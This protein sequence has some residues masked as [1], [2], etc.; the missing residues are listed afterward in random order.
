M[1]WS[2][3][4]DRVMA[5][6]NEASAGRGSALAFSKS[7]RSFQWMTVLS[8]P[9]STRNSTGALTSSRGI[10]TLAPRNGRRRASAE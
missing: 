4:P 5:S 3:M 7:W 9:V 10:A 1:R 2:E 6:G 8:A